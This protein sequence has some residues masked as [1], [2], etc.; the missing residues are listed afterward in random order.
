MS[1]ALGFCV[2]EHST[3]TG[4]VPGHPRGVVG[5]ESELKAGAKT[6]VVNP[7]LTD[8]WGFLLGTEEVAPVLGSRPNPAVTF[9]YLSNR[10]LY[11]NTDWLTI[12]LTGEFYRAAV[13]G[14]DLLSVVSPVLCHT[15][16]FLLELQRKAWD[17][18]T[19]FPYES[20]HQIK[21]GRVWQFKRL[22]P[23]IF[24]KTLLH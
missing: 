9:L 23:N 13:V 22:D 8:D 10:S 1:D 6:W 3:D 21:H 17:T 20:K 16:P 4:P 24:M 2:D 19:I 12:C 14:F 7:E 15:V 11:F 18:T 5:E